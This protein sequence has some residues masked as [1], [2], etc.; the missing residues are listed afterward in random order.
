[1]TSPD[2]RSSPRYLLP[3]PV[4]FRCF[5]IGCAGLEVPTQTLNISCSGLFL[6]S[7]QRL[8][9]GSKLSLNLRV[10]TEISGSV[11]TELR[12]RGRVVHEQEL[13]DG[14]LGYGVEIEQMAPRVHQTLPNEGHCSSACL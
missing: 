13:R 9:V 2:K 10:P 3:I 11:F 8:K 5:E 7:P 12:C 1:M 4:R 14:R 6:L